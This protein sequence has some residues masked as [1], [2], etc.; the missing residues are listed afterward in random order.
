M[1]NP[2]AEYQELDS[3]NAQYDGWYMHQQ[4]YFREKPSRTLL[5]IARP[6]PSLMVPC[7]AWPLLSEC[8][9]VGAEQPLLAFRP[10][11]E[12]AQCPDL[13]CMRDHMSDVAGDEALL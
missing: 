1:A 9:I 11:I 6:F 4:S 3:H 7:G 8:D 2:A 5:K 12:V 10:A 13:S